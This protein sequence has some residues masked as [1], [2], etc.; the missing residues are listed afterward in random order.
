MLIT[1][2]LIDQL[3]TD[4]QIIGIS[5]LERKSD[6]PEEWTFSECFLIFLKYICWI[7]YN[8]VLYQDRIVGHISRDPTVFDIR[9]ITKK[10]SKSK[11]AEKNEKWVSLKTHIPYTI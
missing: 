10:K 1:G 5:G 6:I 8:K 2:Q 4:I 7:E 11:Q 3:H 9:E